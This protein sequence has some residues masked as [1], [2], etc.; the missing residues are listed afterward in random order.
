MMKKII[1]NAVAHVI[2][3]RW[4]LRSLPHM[5]VVAWRQI[6]G[7]WYYFRDRPHW[8]VNDIAELPID[9]ETDKDTR[10]KVLEAR[11]ERQR[12]IDQGM[13]EIGKI[14][15]ELAELLAGMTVQIGGNTDGRP[16]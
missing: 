2:A 5:T 1:R 4:F 3:L 12:R 6:N 15:P 16:R 14:S 7:R 9:D 13:R 8:F 11:A 10:E